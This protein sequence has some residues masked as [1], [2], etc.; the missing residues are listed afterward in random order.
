MPSVTVADQHGVRSESHLGT[1]F[2][3]VHIHAFGIGG[4]YDDSGADAAAG[5]EGTK[6]IGIR[7]AVVTRHRGT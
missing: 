4:G 3:E 2:P 6:E 1:D 5:A 7:P